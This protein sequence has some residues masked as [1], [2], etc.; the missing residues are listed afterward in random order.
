MP[1][2]NVDDLLKNSY[3]IHLPKD[4]RKLEFQRKQFAFHGLKM[5]NIFIACTDDENGFFHFALDKS[6]YTVV[7]N[8]KERGLPFVLVF[9]DDIYMCNGIRDRLQDVLNKI[10]EDC[11][12]LQLGW[13]KNDNS[14]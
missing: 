11:Q 13:T 7:K 14:C 5:P 1:P 2:I 8:A 4:E 10:P 9:E 3:M 12:Y 6:H